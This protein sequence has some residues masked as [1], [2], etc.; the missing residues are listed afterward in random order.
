MSYR[1]RWFLPSAALGLTLAI[2]SVAS[3]Q[4]NPDP[5]S[6]K[7]NAGQS[8]QPIYE[9]WSK[10]PDG[11]FLMH[12]G[13]LNRNY[14]EAME[15]PVGADNKIEPG[16][17]D[18]NQPTFFNP[19]I[20]RMAFSVQVPKDWGKKE[21]VWTLTVH[22]KTERAVA[23]IQPEWEIDP[24]YFGKARSEESLKNKAPKMTLDVPSTATQSTAV[25][26]AATV[27]DDGLLTPRKGP[28]K[29]A[30]GQE[31]PPTLKP[32]PDQPE[33]PVNVPSTGGRGRGPQGPQGL[34]VNWVVWRGPAAVEFDPVTIPVKDGKAV[35]TAK[36]TAPGTYL[37]RA[38]AND[39]ELND[40]KDVTI[41]ITG[42]THQ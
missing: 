13:Y 1:C 10:N 9:G 3:A 15:V 17:A 42:S 27:E 16:T 5:F 21:L 8:V 14:V 26:L 32:L 24:I 35:T 19:R 22:G 23:W 20:H 25:K 36:F 30:V 33:V 18:R 41:T 39:G 31:T 37:L 11:S 12:F 34:M 7:F 2:A 40:Q 28:R 6:F 4:G 29:A 38:I